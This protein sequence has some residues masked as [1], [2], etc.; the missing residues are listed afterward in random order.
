MQSLRLLVVQRVRSSLLEAA[1]LSASLFVAAPAVAQCSL[2]FTPMGVGT[3]PG[4]IVRVLAIARFGNGAIVAGGRFQGIGGVS[5][6]QIATWDG[7]N[8]SALGNGLPSFDSVAALCRRPNGDLIAG[9]QSTGSPA[10]ANIARWDGSTWSPLGAGVSNGVSALA[11]LA[12]GD[13]AVAGNIDFAGGQPV[14]RIARWDGA[15]WSPIGDGF[16]GLGPFTYVEALATLPDGDLVACG[17]FTS[18][19]GQPVLRIAR[20]NGST[21]SPI[22]AG[23]NNVVS[24]L[25]VL[26]DGELIA[27]GQFTAS[28]SV[29]VSHVA[30]FDGTAW[31]PLGAG[32]VG[33]PV[34]TSVEALALLPNGD[35]VAGGSFKFRNQVVTLAFSAWFAVAATN[36][37]TATVGSF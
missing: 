31:V 27:G 34:F 5:T 35:I 15:A 4:G 32:L 30:R 12:N 16:E 33:D 37:V 10:L 9:G 19:G 2:A 36:A 26:P 20:W 8:W 18:S 25:L 29:A 24:S 17:N 21:W 22:G 14:N 23:F 28:G 1:L 3:P 11:N 13:L 6:L 7:A